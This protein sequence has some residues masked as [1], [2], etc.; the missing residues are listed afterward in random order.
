MAYTY[1]RWSFQAAGFV[2]LLLRKL[3][4][5]TKIHIDNNEHMFRYILIS[6]AEISIWRSS[7]WARKMC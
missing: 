6:H 5:I 1:D 2:L 7:T 3:K 4:R